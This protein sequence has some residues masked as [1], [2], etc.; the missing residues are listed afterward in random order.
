MCAR[1]CG[2]GWVVVWRWCGGGVVV[3]GVRRGACAER[4]VASPALAD[5]AALTELAAA[6]AA[7]LAASPAAMPAPGIGAGAGGGPNPAGSASGVGIGI[8]GVGL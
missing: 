2:A 3:G 6:A 5:A 4:M 8:P 7:T 1:E